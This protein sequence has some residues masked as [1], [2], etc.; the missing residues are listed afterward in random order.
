MNFIKELENTQKIEFLSFNK[1]YV[2]QGFRGILAD[3]TNSYGLTNSSITEGNTS[4]FIFLDFRKDSFPLM[5]L[6]QPPSRYQKVITDLQAYLQNNGSNLS[7]INI[8]FAP[9]VGCDHVVV[10]VLFGT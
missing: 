9:N 7:N 10:V 1:I 5:C 4:I 2:F 3:L 6:E 8:E